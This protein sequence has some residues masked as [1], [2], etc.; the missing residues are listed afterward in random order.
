MTPIIEVFFTPASGEIDFRI[1][2]APM[3]T[4]AYAFILSCLAREIATMFNRVDGYDQDQVLGQIVSHFNL[5]V[6]G[7]SPSRPAVPIQ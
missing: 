6:A 3:D 7:P 1:H 5:Q 2:A 4:R